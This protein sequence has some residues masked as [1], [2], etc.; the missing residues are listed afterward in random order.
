MHPADIKASL[1]KAG[2]TQADLAR[3]HHVSNVAVYL[4]INGKS[5]SSKIEKTIAAVIQRHPC[6]IWP[7]WYASTQKQGVAA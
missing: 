1:E 3:H 7:N 5:R 4:V 2:F 6:D